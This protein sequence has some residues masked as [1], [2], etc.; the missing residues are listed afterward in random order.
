[1]RQGSSVCDECA[2][3][4]AAERGAWWQRE[5]EIDLG[6]SGGRAQSD[7]AA[8]IGLQPRRSER[9]LERSLRFAG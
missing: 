3:E 8:Y 2:L 5:A 7:E 6:W 4:A 9:G 1:M